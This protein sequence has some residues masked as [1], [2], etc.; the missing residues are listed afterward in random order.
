MGHCVSSRRHEGLHAVGFFYSFLL[1]P[2][3]ARGF[4]SSKHETVFFNIYI[5]LIRK[6]KDVKANISCLIISQG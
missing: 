3:K 5:L 4:H 6:K 2:V 1:H